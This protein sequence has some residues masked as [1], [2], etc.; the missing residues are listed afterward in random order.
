MIGG[1]LLAIGALGRGKAQAAT[2]RHAIAMHGEPAWP[3]SFTHPT[4]ADPAAPKGGRLM[5]GV[6]GTF[7]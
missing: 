6:L 1:A 7:D 5:Q 4:Y 2:A 3:E